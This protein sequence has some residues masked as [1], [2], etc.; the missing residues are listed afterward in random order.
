MSS[1]SSCPSKICKI[2][3]DLIRVSCCCEAA[4]GEADRIELEV[5]GTGDGGC[6]RPCDSGVAPEAENSALA[7]ADLR[8]LASGFE[9]IAETVVSRRTFARKSNLQRPTDTRGEAR[10]NRNADLCCD[11]AHSRLCFGRWRQ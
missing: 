5:F 8:S 1:S 2:E 9:S 6:M 10:E 11:R 4:T 3:G 7:L